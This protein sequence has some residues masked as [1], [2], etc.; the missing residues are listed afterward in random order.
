MLR[1][2]NKMETEAW[3]VVSR[4]NEGGGALLVIGTDEIAREEIVAKG[5]QHQ[6]YFRYGTIPVSGINKAKAT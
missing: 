2:Q 6:L 5:H 4:R 1:N 3:R